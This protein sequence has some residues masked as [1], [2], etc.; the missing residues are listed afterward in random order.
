MTNSKGDILKLLALIKLKMN[1]LLCYF[2]YL[3]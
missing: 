1:S 3:D 2:N